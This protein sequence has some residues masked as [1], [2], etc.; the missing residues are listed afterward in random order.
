MEKLLKA[1]E[2][3]DRLNVSTQTINNWLKEG[4]PY[5]SLNPHRFEWKE[6]SVW[7]KNRSSRKEV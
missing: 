6:V 4:M 2:L 1:K 7:V 5:F 3:A